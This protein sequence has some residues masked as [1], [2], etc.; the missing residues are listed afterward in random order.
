MY[1]FLQFKPNAKEP[2]RLYDERQL[3]GL[4]QPPAF[5]TVL[6][7]DQDPENFAENGEDPLE[8]VKYMGPMYFDFDGP[9]LDAVLESVRSV[10]TQLT[11]KLDIDKSFIHCWLS[12]KKGVHV[13]VPAK[14]FGLK[15]PMKALPLV[16]R[17]I[18]ETLKVEHLDMVVYSGGRGRMWRCENIQRPTG[19]FKVG[20]TFDELMGMDSEQYATLVAQPRPSMALNEPA[21]SVIFP[22]AEALFKAAKLRAQKRVRAM[23]SATVVPKEK[24]RALTAVPGCIEKLITEGDAPESNWNQAAMQVAAYVAARYER[25]EA[26]EYNEDIVE[27]FVKNVDSSSRPSVKERRKHVDHMLNRAFT[28]RLKF[29]QGPLIATI[30]KPCGHCVICRGDMSAEQAE[31]GKADEDDFDPRTGIRATAIGY[32]LENEGAGRKL[33][34]F[35]FWPH[36]EVYDLEDVSSEQVQFKE[37][38]RRAYIGTLIDDLGQPSEDLEMPE[39]AWSSKRSLIHAVK[40]RNNATVQASDADI[41]NLL[42]AIQELGRRKADQQGKEIEKMVRTHL[43]G[44]LLDRRRDK[45]AAHYVEDAGS[46]TSSGRVSRYF[47]SGDPKQSPKLLSEDYPYEDDTELEEA[48]Y[49]ITK[50]NEPHSIGAIIGWHV[51]CHFREHIQFNEVQFPL[52]NISGNASAGKTSLAILASFLNGMDYGKA[53]FMNVEVSTI[54]P[55]V[56]Y[57]SSSSTVPRLVEEVNPANI[58]ASTYGKILGI[59]KAA[60]NRAPVPRGKLNDKGVA[61]S[62][63]RVSS[64]IVYTSEQTATVPSL[65]SR[66]VEVKLTSKAL[67]KEEYRTHY[68]EAAKRRHALFR[69][70]KALVTQAVNMAP[71]QVLE[72]FESTS[73]LVPD[74]IGPRPKWGYQTT[75]TGLALLAKTMDDYQVRGREHV[76]ALFDAL[77]GFLSNNAGEMEKEKSISEV[78]RVLGTLNQMAEDPE[79]RQTGL[80]PGDHYWRQG[81]SL[82]LVIS[83][84]LP[85]YCRYAKTLGDIPVIRETRQMTSLLE[86]EVYFDRKEQ[87]PH[88][89][90]VDVHVI[91]LSAVRGKGTPLTNFQDETEPEEV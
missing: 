66:T 14:V 74:S 5:M 65:R 69:M 24:L 80:R 73:H 52:L 1:H 49:H 47:Y 67:I 54:Y 59:L 29:L 10:L 13:T 63:D 88:K 23:K 81:D 44:V 28:G 57:V 16:Y 19:T 50:V 38:P 56:R 8:H 71:E 46:C 53:D 40:G 43:C 62:A 64:P 39:D 20:V 17:E 85:R 91:S 90:G 22:K 41:Q 48:L 2:W 26:D 4:E 61:V 18:A 42:R 15:A 58:G 82:F 51:A 78:D 11:K 55:L 45:T 27:P 3:S 79:D 86:G 34:T 87:H 76:D 83:S 36:T 9:D 21:D 68:A 72:I 30:G 75:L 12:G 32:F 60:W 84:C 7:V 6:S 70:A 37:S 35:T 25:D 89:E 33:T 31:Q 77:A